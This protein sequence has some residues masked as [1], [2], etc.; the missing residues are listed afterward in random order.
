MVG[1]SSVNDEA[2]PITNVFKSLERFVQV[3]DKLGQL[4]GSGLTDVAF[5]DDQDQL[6]FLV[7]IQQPLHEEGVG[8]F[9]LLSFVVPEAGTVVEGHALDN[10]LGGYRSFR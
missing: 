2:D 8:D 3:F 6:Y 10:C 5:V 7:D 4:V 9:V 1:G